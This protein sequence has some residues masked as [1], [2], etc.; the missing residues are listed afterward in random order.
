MQRVIPSIMEAA[1]L[2]REGLVERDMLITV[3]LSSSSIQKHTRLYTNLTYS[4]ILIWHIN[5]ADIL[6]DQKSLL[7]LQPSRFDNHL[8]PY[9][10][11]FYSQVKY[12][13]WFHRTVRAV[14]SMTHLSYVVSTHFTFQ[15][16]IHSTV[17]LLIIVSMGY[18]ITLYSQAKQTET[19][20][21]RIQ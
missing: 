13:I 20:L 10:R 21:N 8:G 6:S 12:T 9:L 7:P 11:T 19:P 18:R 4:N 2:L 15:W 5:V 3:E 1:W 17:W 14:S 16:S